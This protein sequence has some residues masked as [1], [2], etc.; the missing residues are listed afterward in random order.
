MSKLVVIFLLLNASFFSFGQKRHV[1]NWN[2]FITDKSINW[3]KLTNFEEALIIDININ[4]ITRSHDTVILR[5]F[6]FDSTSNLLTEVHYN[7]LKVNKPAPKKFNVYYLFDSSGYTYQVNKKLKPINKNYYAFDSLGRM[8]KENNWNYIYDSNN[9]IIEAISDS[10]PCCQPNAKV[11]YIY[12]SNK[13]VK[14]IWHYYSMH[15]R[16]FS[17]EIKTYKIDSCIVDI[18]IINF[19]SENNE[20][21][22]TIIKNGVA[23]TYYYNFNNEI[24]KI[25][26]F[27]PLQPIDMCKLE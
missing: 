5:K 22:K 1:N 6:I 11:E 14:E 26:Q 9:K 21:R 12:N 3:F 4:T 2:S 27:K 20:K 19:D 10:L 25:Q 13:L 7:N 15:R 8:I 24:Y 17:K 16:L 18:E 23:N